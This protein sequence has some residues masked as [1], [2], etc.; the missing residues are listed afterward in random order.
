MRAHAG[1]YLLYLLMSFEDIYDFLILSTDKQ[2]HRM[3]ASSIELLRNLLYS[4]LM[5]YLMLLNLMNY[6]P[7]HKHKAIAPYCI[8]KHVSKIL[9]TW[10]LLDKCKF[11]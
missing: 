10:N 7:M 11:L 2:T 3:T 6:N 8:S 9:E 4:N 1:Q 5:C